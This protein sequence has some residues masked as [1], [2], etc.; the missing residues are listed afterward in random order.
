MQSTAICTTP[1]PTVH[2]TRSM[3]GAR[4]CLTLRECFETS[5]QTPTSP[6]LSRRV[7]M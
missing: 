2:E 7:R 5:L 3:A 1:E 4:A 6:L